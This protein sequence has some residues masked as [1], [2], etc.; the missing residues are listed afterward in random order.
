MEKP[1]KKEDAAIISRELEELER[2]TRDVQKGKPKVRLFFGF[3]FR[4]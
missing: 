1:L 2:F 3:F 4:R